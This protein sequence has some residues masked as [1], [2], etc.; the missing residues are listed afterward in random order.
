MRNANSK[1]A[2]DEATAVPA[3]WRVEAP[4]HFDLRVPFWIK[5]ALVALLTAGAFLIDRPVAAWTIAHS[6]AFWDIASSDPHARK[7]DVARDLMWLE[8]FGHPACVVAVVLAVGLLDRAG[9]KKALAIGIAC[10]ATLVVTHLLKDTLGRSRPNT[11][12]G[13]PG[14]VAGEWVWGGP[15]VGFGGGAAWTSF[16][17]AHTT[18]AFGLASALAW[19]YPRGRALF[20]GLAVITAGQ[21]IMHH[22]H[23]VSD[24]IAGL[25]CGVLVARTTLRLNL[26]G[27]WIAASPGAVRRWWLQERQDGGP[28]G[29]GGGR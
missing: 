27:R 11:W 13:I 17:S 9:R 22:A 14:L 20:M 28:D 12:G 24:T 23:F 7:G 2:L 6:N 18:A 16:P 4:A 19:F 5:L 15:R 21:R 29:E 1:G 10:L 3:L 26:A 25:G 8:Q